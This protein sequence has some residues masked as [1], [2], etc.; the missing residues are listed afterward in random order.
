MLVVDDE[1]LIRDM[2]RSALERFGYKVLIAK[3]G[4]E[5]ISVFEK[6]A[7]CIQAVLLDLTMPVMSGKEALEIL[8]QK[9]PGLKVI[10]MSGYG[11]TEALRLFPGN[12]VSSFIQ[13]PFTGATLG[14]RLKATLSGTLQPLA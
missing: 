8:R 14:E 9:C 7:A 2:A 13:K 6:H 11:E 5:A 10:L 3:D 4:G 1:E 12:Q